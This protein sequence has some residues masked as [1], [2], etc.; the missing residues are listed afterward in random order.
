LLVVHVD[1][2]TDP[3]GHT[4]LCDG[5]NQPRGDGLEEKAALLQVSIPWLFFDFDCEQNRSQEKIDDVTVFRFGKLRFYR[6]KFS[7]S[8]KLYHFR[9]PTKSL[10][11]INMIASLVEML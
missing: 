11:L 8:Q 2:C 4:V 10:N 3:H 5:E 6:W 9:E 7:H 1:I